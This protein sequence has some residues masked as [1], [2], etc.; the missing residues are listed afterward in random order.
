MGKKEGK[1]NGDRGKSG[2]GKK[3]NR[4]EFLKASALVSTGAGLTI[5]SPKWTFGSSQPSG[6]PKIIYWAT[7]DVGS[8]MYIIPTIVA[9]KIEPVMKCK[10]RMIPA[11]DVNKIHMLREGRA[12]IATMAADNYWATMGLGDYATLALGP[13]PLRIV[14][15]GMPFGSG[16]TGLATRTS[17]IKTP[18]DLKGKRLAVVVGAVWSKMGQEA[19]LAFGNLSWKDVKVYEV[20]STGA[21]YKSLVDG[22]ADCTQGAVS[23]PGTYEIESSPYGLTIMRYPHS[24]VE[25]WKRYNNVVPYAFPGWST[26]GAGIKPG[27][28]IPTPIYPFPIT[29]TL[30]SQSEELIYA[31][32]KAWYSKLDQILPANPLCKSM[33]VAANMDPRVVRMAPFHKGAVKFF[34]EIGAWK[35][36][37]EVANNNA[38]AHLEKVKKRWDAFVI[39]CENRMAKTG[40][41]INTKKEWPLIVRKDVALLPKE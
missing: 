28:K 9:Q 12:Q 26:Q 21:M 18:Y 3:M 37:N 40:K 23:A 16:S 25:A 4:R 41:K 14:W 31:L 35:P 2:T 5:I 17:G 1:E 30:E 19:N 15:A 13:Q 34:K 24:D 36:L 7:S 6:I 27:Q 8:S 38:L 10:F 20:S 22:F 11:V 29:N 32:C 33:T 39:E